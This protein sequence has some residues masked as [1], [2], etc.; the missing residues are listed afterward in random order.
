MNK[1]EY[2]PIAMQNECFGGRIGTDSKE[3]T[4]IV[5]LMAQ[6]KLYKYYKNDAITFPN[7]EALADY[8]DKTKIKVLSEKKFKELK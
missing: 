7:A 8:L 4:V 3:L 1:L 5:K 2:K 6:G